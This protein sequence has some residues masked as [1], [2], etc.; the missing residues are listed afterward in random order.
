VERPATDGY[1]LPSLAKRQ[2]DSLS[3]PYDGGAPLLSVRM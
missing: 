3:K 1:A 2:T